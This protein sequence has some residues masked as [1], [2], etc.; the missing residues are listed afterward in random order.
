MGLKD[1]FLV[2]GKGCSASALFLAKVPF[3]VGDRL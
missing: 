1:L 3:G 2:F